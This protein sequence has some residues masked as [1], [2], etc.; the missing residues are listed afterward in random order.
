MLEQNEEIGSCF[1]TP[2][3]DANYIMDTSPIVRRKDEDPYGEYRTKG[4]DPRNLRCPAANDLYGTTLFRVGSAR[5]L[6]DP[7]LDT[8]GRNQ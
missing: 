3:D 4:C 5:P 6:A 7:P 2:R 8:Q 1:A